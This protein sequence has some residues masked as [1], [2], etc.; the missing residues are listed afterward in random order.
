MLVA[1]VP[2]I[3][4]DGGLGVFYGQTIGFQLD[5]ESPFSVWG[6]NSGLE[7]LLWLV[8]V[9]VV[10]LAVAVAFSPAGATPSRSPRSGPRC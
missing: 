1:V 6:Q 7:P 8:K 4:A 3:P 10:G 5:R 2:H 9:A